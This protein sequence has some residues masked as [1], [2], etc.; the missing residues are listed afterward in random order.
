MALNRCFVK[1]SRDFACSL[2]CVTSATAIPPASIESLTLAAKPLSFRIAIVYFWD[3][4]FLFLFLFPFSFLSLSCLS[5]SPSPQQPLSS[6]SLRFISSILPLA[7][8]C[9]PIKR[10]VLSLSYSCCSSVHLLVSRLWRAL[11]NTHQKSTLV[12][13]QFL[14]VHFSSLMAFKTTIFDVQTYLLSNFISSNRTHMFS[15]PLVFLIEWRI[16]HHLHALELAESSDAHEYITEHHKNRLWKVL[17]SNFTSRTDV[18]LCGNQALLKAAAVKIWILGEGGK[19]TR[20]RSTRRR[21]FVGS[22]RRA[23][24]KD[25]VA[26][27][28]ATFLVKVRAHQW[29]PADIQAHKAISNKD[30]AV[31][32]HDRTNREVFTWQEPRRKGGQVSYQNWKLMWN[33]VARKVLRQGSVEEE[34]HEHRHRVCV[35]LFY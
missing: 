34:V 18:C 22:N 17:I 24:K 2:A 30:I 11:R 14:H 20:V 15:H 21:H 29:E 7:D 35:A 33:N 27:G 6:S 4:I 31:E 13:Q 28:A 9:A 23:Q 32:W 5:F 25:T 3:F 8:V 12:V 10:A 1:N 19:A 16:T 26:A